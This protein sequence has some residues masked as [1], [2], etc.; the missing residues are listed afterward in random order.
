[1]SIEDRDFAVERNLQSSIDNGY[2]VWVVGDIHGY[3]ET[4]SIL[5]EKLKINENDKVIF[6]GD[7]I[8]RGPKS[9]FLLNE[10]SRNKNFFSVMGNHEYMM[11]K[12]LKFKKSRDL[13]SWYKYG[14][15]ETILS[16][17][18]D[19]ENA[20]LLANKYLDL[21][22][23]LPIEIVLDNFRIVHAGYNSGKQLSEQT[24]SDRIWSREI[25]N[26]NDIIDK[27]RQI[28]V[29]HTPTQNIHDSPEP[30][31]SKIMIDE[32][33]PSIIGIDTGLGIVTDE[34]RLTAYNLQTREFLQVSKV[35]E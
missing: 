24:I 30:W 28:I 23:E 19:T 2:S 34:S 5:L 27:D 26:T 32:L 1:M 9:S 12:A 33:T 13:K 20:I 11:Y 25:F 31:L 4:F 35:E 6:I 10:L 29:G 22:G 16:F 14:G 15:E 17:D 21:I 7:L 8:D 3:S 18:N